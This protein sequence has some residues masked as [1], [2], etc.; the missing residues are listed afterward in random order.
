M[1]RIIDVN[2][3]NCDEF[4][5]YLGDDVS[6]NIGREYYRGI[7]AV[8]DI[9]D[10]TAGGMVWVLKNLE[11]ALDTESNIVFIKSVLFF[12]NVFAPS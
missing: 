5:G 7:V 3:Q 8:S 10:L 9:G 6:E 11:T 1:Y 12:N 4:M 2:S